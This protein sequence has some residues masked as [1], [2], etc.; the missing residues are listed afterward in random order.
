MKCPI[1]PKCELACPASHRIS[2]G[3]SDC[4]R[5]SLALDAENIVHV[6]GMG[7][8][9]LLGLSPVK[10]YAREIIGTE[11]STQSYSASFF[12]NQAT[13]SGY[14]HN[15]PPQHSRCR[16]T[17]LW[18]RFTWAPAHSRQQAGKMHFTRLA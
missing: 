10:Y 13:P 7:I 11:I 3:R 12:K 14:S 1:H 17:G 18:L 8:D 4:L 6:K 5:L 2:S 16:I 15:D 9:S